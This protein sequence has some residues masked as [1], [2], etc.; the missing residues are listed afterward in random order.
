M[1]ARAASL[2]QKQQ[3]TAYYGNLPCRHEQRLCSRSKDYCVASVTRQLRAELSIA[4]W[5]ASCAYA[6]SE[7]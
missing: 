5:D 6:R 1:T 4:G 7:V 3:I 2:C